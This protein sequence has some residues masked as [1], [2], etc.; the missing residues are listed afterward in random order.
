LVSFSNFTTLDPDTAT[1]ARELTENADRQ[2]SAFMSFVNIWMAFNGWMESITEATTDADMITALAENRRVM[3]AYNGLMDE[4]AD[5]RR[6]VL[7]FST[8]WPV[9]NVRDARRKLGREAFWRLSREELLQECRRENVRIQPTGWTNGDLPTWPQLLR[10]IYTI[11]CNMFHGTKS[12]QN[13]RDR[14][15]VLH[16]DRILRKFINQSGCFDWSD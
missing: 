3:D 4:A 16:S 7:T 11:R 13:S 8:M 5:F 14:E 12:P 2:R 1:L 6:R 10:T 15:L 9:L